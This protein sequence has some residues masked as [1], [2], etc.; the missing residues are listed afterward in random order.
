MEP[1][2]PTDPL[3]LAPDAMVLADHERLLVRRTWV[4]VTDG[5]ALTRLGTRQRD[6]VAAAQPGQAWN[7][8]CLPP[9]ATPLRDDKRVPTPGRYS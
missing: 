9:D 3:R 8:H 1:R 6:N 4:G 2:Q 5:A 7:L